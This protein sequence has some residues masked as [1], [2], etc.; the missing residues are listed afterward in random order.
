[1]ADDST[2]G[3]LI[4]FPGG[5][6]ESSYTPP[7]IPSYGDTIPDR[8]P[9]SPVPP[10]T[11][12]ET[13]M[14]LP[15]IPSLADPASYLES[16][17]IP[18]AGEDGDSGD[19]EEEGEYEIPRSL[20]DR[21]GDWLEYRIALGHARLE[22]EAP[23]RE[24]EI[25]QK[26]ARMT[27]QTDREVGLMAQQNKLRQAQIKAQADRTAARFG[28]G[29]G[30]GA[31]GGRSWQSSGMGADKGRKH[32]SGGGGGS[33][34]FNSPGRNG[35]GNGPFGGG[36]KGGNGGGNGSLGS[37]G[38]S[39]GSSAGGHNRVA[40]GNAG[41]D[42]TGRQNGSGGLGGGRSGAGLERARGR[43]ERA[44]ARQA[45]GLADLTKDRDQARQNKQVRRDERK[46]RRDN[47][48]R[49]TLGEALGRE[50]ERRFERRRAAVGGSQAGTSGP[51]VDLV[52]K[53]ASAGG[54][55]TGKDTSGPKVD[56]VKKPGGAA[57]KPG[58]SGP[59]VD[60]DK[61]PGSK[62][63]SSSGDQ[64]KPDE[65]KPDEVKPGEAKPEETEAEEAKPDE[66]ATKPDDGDG[67]SG[68]TRAAAEPDSG[69]AKEKGRADGDAAAGPDHD[70]DEDEDDWGFTAD[71][72]VHEDGTSDWFRWGSKARER[73]R[74]RERSEDGPAGSGSTE[75]P[76]VDFPGRP[77]KPSPATEEKPETEEYPDA[78][79]VEPA[80]LP[81][82]PVRHTERPG[83]S[84]PTPQEST[85]T[86]AGPGSGSHQ[87]AAQH[88][89]DVTFDQYLTE[90]A[91]IAV[92]AEQDKEEAEA[93]AEALGK[94]AD[95]L[96]EMAADLVGDHNIA[97]QVTELIANLAD[98]ADAMKA[99]AVRCAA[100]CQ[101]ASEAATMAA[102]A[103]ART[104][105]EDLNA[106]D[107][108]GLAHASAAAHHD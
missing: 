27:A 57:G 32:R 80:A 54:G 11:P 24:A 34:G 4:P 29:S 43:Q 1:M 2:D 78:E 5:G 37:G 97:T 94:V 106:M 108:A 83:T 53:P 3:R 28:S 49:V 17:G 95:A 102:R 52:K 25:E 16:E 62:P 35:G 48:D 75:V 40:R 81:P 86:T 73:E 88:R 56:L 23:F 92:A 47:P 67:K 7:P 104:Y 107:E 61:K 77:A 91:N 66:G 39:A 58:E 96:R 71:W 87:M 103:V 9:D 15:A 31:G 12:E 18:A 79:I 42:L 41:G 46:A 21:L 38:K 19:L 51:K 89:T 72:R 101:A 55:S 8:D 13:T 50:A 60:L 44:A 33:S 64:A 76:V 10:E 82:A 20:A 30:G 100:D 14:E 65:L 99:Q 69:T 6:G 22:A 105:S 74:R 90:I 36:K 59:K 63:G 93:L 45:A 84:R 85:V 70:P 26:V 98:A 68:D